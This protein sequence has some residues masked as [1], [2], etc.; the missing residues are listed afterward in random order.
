[1]SDGNPRG[2]G[3]FI[4]HSI[5]L[6]DTVLDWIVALRGIG[7]EAVYELKLETVRVT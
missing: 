4:A 1:L 5:D 3:G 7:R 6:L 2:K